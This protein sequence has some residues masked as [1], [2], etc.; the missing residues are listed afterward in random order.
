MRLSMV[1]PDLPPAL[2]AALEGLV[3]V[4][5]TMLIGALLAGTPVPP[6]YV[7]GV[8]YGQEPHGREWWQTVADT[9]AELERT[10]RRNK[11]STTDCE[12]LAGVRCAELRLGALLA[13]LVGVSPTSRRAALRAVG[14]APQL[15]YSIFPAVACC[16]RTGPRSYHA[17]VRHP[18]GHIEDPSRVLGMKSR[19]PPLMGKAKRH[20]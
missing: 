3:L 11:V 20:G 4:N 5:V 12:D 8:R 1:V 15:S 7:S 18:D 9:H 6:L 2:N 19:R 17:I 10:K 16:V 14:N 13:A